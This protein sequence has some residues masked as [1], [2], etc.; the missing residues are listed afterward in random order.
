MYEF[1]SQIAQTWGLL[2]FVAAFALVLV[3]ALSPSNR[4]RF[5]KARQMPLEDEDDDDVRA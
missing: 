3:Y 2:L 1:L 4:D 5:E